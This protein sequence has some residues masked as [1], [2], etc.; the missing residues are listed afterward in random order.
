M[1]VAP[2]RG[3]GWT[4]AQLTPKAWLETLALGAAAAALLAARRVRRVRVTGESMRPTLERGD[5]VLVVLGAPIR[6][7]HVVLLDDPE[8]P[9]GG[10]TV[11]K[12]VAAVDG[13]RVTVVGDRAT[14]S[15]DSRHYG[16]VRRSAVRGR[17]VYR[18][19]PPERA[20]CVR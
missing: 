2:L 11:V 14:L 6:P 12:R 3:F 7:G 4:V 5:R 1:L 18:Y 8:D 13:D 9:S 10:R 15:V 19:Q 20:G 17:V 16:P